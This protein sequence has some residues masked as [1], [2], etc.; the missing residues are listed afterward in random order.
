M[1]TEAQIVELALENL[2]KNAGITGVWKPIGIKELDGKLEL[3]LNNKNVKFNTEIKK[4][5]RGHQIQRILAQAERFNPLIVI[6]QNIFPKIKE[7]LRRHQVAYL[8][9]NGN[10]FLNQDGH[11]IW[12]DLHKALPVKEEKVNRTFTKTGLKVL[13]CFLLNEDLLNLTY[14]DIATLADVALGNI[15]YV[16]TGLK[17]QNFLLKVGENRYKL[18]NKKELFEKW[19]AAYEKRLKPTLEI[20]TFRFAKADDFRNWQNLALNTER[21]KWGGEPAGD[22]LTNYLKP[23]DLTLYTTE[24]KSELIKNY[25]IVPD[26]HGN[27][28]IFQMFWRDEVVN[29]Y[30]KL[31]QYNVTPPLL[32]YTDLMNTNDRR[33]IETAEKVYERYLQDEF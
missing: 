4:E 29:T 1:N 16:I 28:K 12:L 27:I 23:K 3:K 26:A 7:E 21:T 11:F 8:E 32:V 25:R 33:C 15:N 31:K 10:I 2:Q 30:P 13:F 9:T 17:E 24:K 19:I 18:Q 22:L 20:G 5:L 6:A 14:R